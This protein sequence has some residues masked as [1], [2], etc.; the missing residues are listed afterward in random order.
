MSINMVIVDG[1]LTDYPEIRV[2]ANGRKVLYFSIA[3]DVGTKENPNAEF[4]DFVAYEGRA[5]TIAKYF[6]KGDQ[7]IVQGRNHFYSADDRGEKRRRCVVI[8]DRFSFG[9]KKRTENITP[10]EEKN[11]RPSAFDSDFF[12]EEKNESMTF[13]NI[14]PD[15]LPFY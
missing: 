4:H 1:R 13:N 7:I 11:E 3:V 2:N 6:G 9:Q 12:R 14:M 15:D 10:A 5:E 8:V